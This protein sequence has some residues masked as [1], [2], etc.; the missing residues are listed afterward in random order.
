[1][2]RFCIKTWA[3]LT[4]KIDSWFVNKILGF[5][6]ISVEL[7]TFLENYKFN[8]SLISGEKRERFK[9]KSISFNIIVNRNK[10]SGPGH[11]LR[12]RAPPN[13]T[14]NN[15]LNE[16]VEVLQSGTPIAYLCVPGTGLF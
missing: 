5:S 1:M 3:E 11:I 10:F 4:V 6:I 12:A 15:S 16:A 8:T 14:L 9:K 13:I 2:Y 7:I